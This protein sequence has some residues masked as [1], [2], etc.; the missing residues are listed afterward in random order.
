MWQ[1]T[2][3]KHRV[4]EPLREERMSLRV[5]V[6][7]PEGSGKAHVTWN[8]VAGADGKGLNIRTLGD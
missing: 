7:F 3:C 4:P 6:L 8:V 5:V 2:Q 1:N